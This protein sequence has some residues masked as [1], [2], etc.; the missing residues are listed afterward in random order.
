MRGHH[1]YQRRSHLDFVQGRVQVHAGLRHS[2]L[3]K[4]IA[5]SGSERHEAVHIDTYA[6]LS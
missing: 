3:H 4:P 6:L 1:S 2:S 5:V